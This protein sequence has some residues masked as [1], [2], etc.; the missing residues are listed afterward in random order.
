MY[1][2]TLLQIKRICPGISTERI[3]TILETLAMFTAEKVQKSS[4][5][6]FCN[7]IEEC[8]S[9][10]H[11]AVFSGP[12]AGCRSENVLNIYGHAGAARI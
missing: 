2:E 1:Y 11:Q 12:C 10:N 5:S 3:N 9:R 7:K 4:V 6:N 8:L